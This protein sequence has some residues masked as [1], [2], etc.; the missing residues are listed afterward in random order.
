MN[1]LVRLG[2]RAGKDNWVE[3]TIVR[4]EG[5]ASSMITVAYATSDLSAKAVRASMLGV[6][7][8]SFLRG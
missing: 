2:T 1:V 5:Y 4:D 8:M 6:F 3:L 7:S